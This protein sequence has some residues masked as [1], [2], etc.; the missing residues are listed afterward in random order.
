MRGS[1]KGNEPEALRSWKEGQLNAGQKPR[2]IDLRGAPEHQ[3]T[4]KALFAE[5]TGQC[6]YCSRGIDLEEHNR[7]HIE[8]FRPQSRY[9]DKELAHENLFLSCGPRQSQGSA[10][11][12][13]CGNRKDNWFDE[14]CHVEPS[15]EDACQRYFVFASDGRVQGKGT[16]AAKV[17]EVLYLNHSELRA[18]RSTLIDYLD[19]ELNNGVSLCKLIKSYDDV[20]SSGARVSFANVAIQY[21]RNQGGCPKPA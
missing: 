2:Y 11:Q 10:Q 20:S 5:Q 8:H 14:D 17:I 16:A 19:G 12:P 1:A 21:L 13:T 15:P 6:V 4:K 9:P 7:H 18:E 3:A